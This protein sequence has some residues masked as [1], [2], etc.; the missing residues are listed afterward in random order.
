MKFVLIA[1]VVL[2]SVAQALAFAIPPNSQS[3]IIFWQGDKA[4]NVPE[5]RQII[6]ARGGEVVCQ[7][8]ESLGNICA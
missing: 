2:A 5:A 1:S 8:S 7:Y 3:Y 6:A 4:K